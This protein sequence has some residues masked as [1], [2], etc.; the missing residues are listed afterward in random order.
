MTRQAQAPSAGSR[1]VC[2]CEREGGKR[3]S[4]IHPN[5]PPLL[6]SPLRQSAPAR[7]LLQGEMPIQQ[8]THDIADADGDGDGDGDGGPSPVDKRGGDLAHLD[9]GG[10][11]NGSLLLDGFFSSRPWPEIEECVCHVVLGT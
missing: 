4:A 11:G 5:P 8:V 6:F 7:L 10:V 2:V 1:L 3:P 9:G